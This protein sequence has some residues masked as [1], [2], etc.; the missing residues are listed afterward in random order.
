M[1]LADV[2]KV[3]KMGS[4]EV[5]AVKGISLKI[6]KGEFVAICGASGSGKST[7]LNLVGALDIPTTGSV[8]LDG[9]NIT[10]LSESKLARLRGKTI[11]FVF[12]TFNLYPSLNVFE[13]IA[14]PM[15][16]HEFSEEEIKSKVNELMKL[17]GL[18]NRALHLPAELSGGE[19][20]RVALARALSTSPALVLADEPTGNLDSKTGIEIM[21]LLD[22]L[23][24]KQGKTIIVVTHDLSVAKHAQKIITLSDGKIVSIE[25][26]KG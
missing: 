13:N 23:H 9:I 8:F 22:D 2:K 21:K 25:Q 16:I 20:Q 1:E 19:R 6:K 7:V 18:T 3:Y 12:Q 4:V 11:G 15:R 17:V 24:N 10:E 26:Q 14:L 5:Q